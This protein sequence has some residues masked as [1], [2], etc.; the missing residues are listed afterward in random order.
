V[1]AFTP[2]SNLFADNALIYYN[3]VLFGTSPS[4]AARKAG[5][6][7]RTKLSGKTVILH[8]FD[9]IN[10]PKDGWSPEGS[11]ILGSDG[12]FYGTTESGGSSD[13]G[14]IF[15]LN[16][17]TPYQFTSLYSFGNEGSTPKAALLQAKD[18]NYYGTTFR[19]AAGNGGTIFQMTPAG[20]VTILYQFP[21]VLTNEGPA[22]PLIQASDGNFY[23]TTE[24]GG[25]YSLGSVFKMT[26]NFKV[27]TLHSFGN[28]TDG[29][30]ANGALVQGPNRNL[31]G[32]T[33]RGGTAKV[34][35]IYEISTDG[36]SYTILH[37]FADGSVTNDGYEPS[38][39]LTVGS[40]NNLYGTTT[41]GGSANLGTIFKIS[42]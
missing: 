23:G 4:G 32:M 39:A 11:L 29:F 41:M 37:N 3:G 9:A 6:V 21:N 5:V 19:G 33:A 26:A 16:P 20:K 22:A 12:Y 38:G 15:K 28:G 34:G 2:S 40:D 7:F 17:M 13:H 8:Q 25:K 10:T 27:T 24:A 18:G 14:T 42:P 35:T 1:H 36:S 31:Y 30:I